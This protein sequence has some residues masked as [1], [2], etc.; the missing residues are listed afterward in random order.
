MGVG[1]RAEGRGL[2]F[3]AARSMIEFP[4]GGT[5]DLVQA[6][7]RRGVLSTAEGAAL[8]L[9]RDE[10]SSQEA[11][12]I[13]TLGPSVLAVEGGRCPCRSMRTASPLRRAPWPERSRWRRFAHPG[14]RRLPW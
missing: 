2:V 1:L 6:G 12:G 4:G 10:G 9:A 11:F 13:Q 5:V 3:E 14:D 8:V 7:E